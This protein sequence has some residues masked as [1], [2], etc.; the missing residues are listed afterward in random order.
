MDTTLDG[1]L[2]GRVNIEQPVDGYRAATDPVY[3][4]A[5]IPALAGD[6]ILDVGCGVG[7]ASF[8]LGERIA[9][10]D[11]TG[12]ELQDNYATMA[13][14]N[15][16]RNQQAMNIT[17]ANLANLP[18]DLRTQS[19][20]HVMTNP[21]FFQGEL[22]SAPDNAAKALA[23]V[24]TMDLDTWIAISLKRLKSRGSFSIIHLAQRLPT[25]LAAMDGACGDIRVLP[26]AARY[27]RDAKRV[28]VQGIKTS[29][30]PMRLLPPL[31]V[32]DGANH[33]QDGDDYSD[34]TRAIL[35]DGQSLQL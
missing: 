34:T 22:L 17:C 21:P 10:L 23:H 6:R 27:G 14:A 19:F 15:A 28:L 4:A 1:F 35:R 16:T 3:L 29:K 11:L 13:R 24:E 9:D 5:C 12:V 33:G 2:G 20:D 30:A 18:T 32:H 8:C 26:I 31:I 7:T 25:I